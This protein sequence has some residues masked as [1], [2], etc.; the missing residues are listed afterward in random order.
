[1]GRNA[2]RPKMSIGFCR[3]D[4][5]DGCRVPCRAAFRPSGRWSACGLAGRDRQWT[6]NAGLTAGQ[7][8]TG[9]QR[10]PGSQLSR[11]ERETRVGHRR[12]RRCGWHE[13]SAGICMIPREC[14]VTAVTDVT[15]DSCQ[16]STSYFGEAVIELASCWRASD[17]CSGVI[18][19]SSSV[20]FPS[21]PSAPLRCACAYQ[22]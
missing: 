14:G 13:T 6:G 15:P 4:R 9:I 10:S 19:D 11:Q 18:L 7:V 3:R 20:T 17:S 22:T 8:V 16:L 5:F 1:M 12:E 21:A 2:G